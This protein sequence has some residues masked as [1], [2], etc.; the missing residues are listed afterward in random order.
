MTAQQPSRLARL[1]G[2]LPFQAPQNKTSSH[3][4][5]LLALGGRQSTAIAS[6]WASFH[7]FNYS[8]ALRK[9]SRFRGPP[10]LPFRKTGRKAASRSTPIAG[11]PRAPQGRLP[12]GLPRLDHHPSSSLGFSSRRLTRAGGRLP[13]ASVGEVP[14]FSGSLG[15]AP[16]ANSGARTSPSDGRA[17][18]SPRQN[19]ALFLPSFLLSRGGCRPPEP[20]SLC[21]GGRGPPLLTRPP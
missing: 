11:L 16:K 21:Q 1:H 18:G 2:L 14:S 17:E 13:K 3:L 4:E 12:A 5:R 6:A 9:R 7:P 20:L 15:E 19:G 8:Q 10:T